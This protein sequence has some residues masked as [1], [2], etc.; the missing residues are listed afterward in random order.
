MRPLRQIFATEPALAGFL[1][2]RQ[3]EIAVLQLLRDNL[4]PALAM[5]IG[6]ADT[7]PPEL[8]L[9]AASGAASGLLRQRAPTLLQVLQRAGLE[10]TGIRV[11]VQA[12]SRG[13]PVHKTIAKQLDT[14]SAATLR[15]GAGGVADP[16]LA[17]AIRRLADN[18]RET[19][20]TKAQVLPEGI[21]HEHPE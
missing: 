8:A 11:H 7:L 6:V 5:Q 3:R 18:A 21:K 12:R 9:V 16:A 20:S 13:D 15:A 14:A 2:R 17:A 1:D 4:P 19:G 10:F